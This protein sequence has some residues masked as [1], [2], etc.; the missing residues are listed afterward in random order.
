[1]NAYW[2]NW[3]ALAIVAGA[4]AHVGFRVWIM[5]ATKEQSDCGGGCHGCTAK[6]D[7][8]RPTSPLVSLE[9]LNDL[10]NR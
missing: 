2:Q 4:A 7:T 8:D 5:F 9:L 3:V 1:M 10:P 6:A